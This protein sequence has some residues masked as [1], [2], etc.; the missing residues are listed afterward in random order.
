[1]VTATF[2][3]R[4]HTHNEAFAELDAAIDDV[5]E[6]SDGFLGRKR[7]HDDEGHRSVVYYWRSMQDLESFRKDATHRM[8][9]SRY[10]EWYEGYRVEIAEVTLVRG[11]DVYRDWP[12][13]K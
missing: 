5:A 2:I 4:Q 7:W 12:G 3:F 8:A 11:D 9:K 6:S 13:Q 10:K 1:M